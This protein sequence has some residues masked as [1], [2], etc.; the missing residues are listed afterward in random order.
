MYFYCRLLRHWIQKILNS[1]ISFY[2]EFNCHAHLGQ[3]FISQNNLDQG[4]GIY[5][6]PRQSFSNGQCFF[7]SY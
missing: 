2:F 7:E 5:I 6:N 4:F 1:E 3:T